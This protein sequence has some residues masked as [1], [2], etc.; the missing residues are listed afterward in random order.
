MKTIVLENG[1]E[2]DIP[3]ELIHFLDRSQMKWNWYD[4]RQKFWPENRAKTIK[5]FSGLPEGQVFACH[6][7]FDGY[8]QLELMI[9]LLHALKDK[10]FTLY[11]M[12]GMLTNDLFEFYNKT[13]S[14]ITPNELYKELEREDITDE[15][16]DAVYEKMD[17]FKREMNQKFL[18][19]LPAHNIIWVRRF[20][21]QIPLKSL[22]DIKNNLH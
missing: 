12:H 20:S 8:D 15:E 2:Q 10:K 6:T 9:Q 14:S 18:E 3:E 11:I 1:L 16:A 7:C 4:M 22:D 17:D 5:Y 21:M 19:V 13:S